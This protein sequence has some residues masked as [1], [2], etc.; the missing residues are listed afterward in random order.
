MSQQAPEKALKAYFYSQGAE[1]VWG[2]SSSE[3]CADAGRYDKG[4]LKLQHF[5]ALLDTF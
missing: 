4:F 2:H 3:L 1:T 5:A